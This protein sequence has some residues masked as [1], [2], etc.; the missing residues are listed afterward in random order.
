[1]TRLH[2]GHLEALA[3]A[4]GLKLTPQ[5]RAIVA[6]LAEAHHHPAAE[7]VL[8]A[9]NRRFPMTSRATVYNTLNMLKEA[10][11]VKE[12]FENGVARIDPNL[13]GHHHFVCRSCGSMSDVD[14]NVAP[15]LEAAGLPDGAEVETFA[16]TFRGVCGKCRRAKSSDG[17][18]SGKN[19]Q[20]RG[21]KHAR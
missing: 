19:S 6:Y 7:E 1:M 16:V 14:W 11:L 9:I 8:R 3:E 2:S 5:R 15:R 18:K 4:R 21:T 20:R 13:A 12:V 10:G 17:P